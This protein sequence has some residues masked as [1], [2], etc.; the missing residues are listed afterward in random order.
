MSQQLIYTHNPR[1]E[2]EIYKITF[3]PLVEWMTEIDSSC[4]H[5]PF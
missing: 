2:F 1:G 4:G 3:Q 5:E